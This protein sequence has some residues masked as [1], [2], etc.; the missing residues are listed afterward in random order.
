MFLGLMAAALV[1]PLTVAAQMRDLVQGGRSGSASGNS[2]DGN[3][4]GGGPA[5]PRATTGPEPA[6]IVRQIFETYRADKIPKPPWSP[7]MAARLR[8]ADLGADP[9]LS[10]QDFDIKSFNVGQI[11]RTSDAAAVEVR[12]VNLGQS[13]HSVFDFRIVDGKWVI[14]NYRFLSANAP[15]SDLRRELK[16][17][18]LK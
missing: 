2:A 18:P 10:A 3:N 16:L 11:S 13:K 1:L 4:L 15:I 6:A 14:A 7:A 17:P 12:F 8:R 9:I 5:A